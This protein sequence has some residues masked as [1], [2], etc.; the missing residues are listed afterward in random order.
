LKQ[1]WRPRAWEIRRRLGGG[2][3]QSGILAAAGLYALEHNLSRLGEDHENAK[4]LAA[5]LSDSQTV[6]RSDPESNIV[7][8][9]LLREQDTAESVIPLLAQAGVLVS[10]YGPRRVRA[11]THLDVTRADVERA[12]RI[13]RETL[14]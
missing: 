10:P 12:A 13:I 9:D 11:V 7:M 4:E 5:I 8:I 3:R 1:A 6:R 14:R 2:M